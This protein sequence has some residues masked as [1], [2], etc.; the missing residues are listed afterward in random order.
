MDFSRRF[1]WDGNESMTDKEQLVERYLVKIAESLDI[2]ATMREKAE[3]SYRTV[4]EWLDDC[5]ADS[6]VKIMPQGSF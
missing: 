4:G 2:S 1:S 5:N 6:D 3:K